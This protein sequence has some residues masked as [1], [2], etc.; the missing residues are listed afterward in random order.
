MRG[1]WL[2]F[3]A[4][5]AITAGCQAQPVAP[6]ET[7]SPPPTATAEPT[8][9]PP[10]TST[11]VPTPTVTPTPFP[12][13][14]PPA[15]PLDPFDQARRLGRGVNLGNALEAPTEGEWGV[16]LE[17]AYFRLIAEAGFDT[18]RVPIRWSAHAMAEPPYTI[19]AAFFQRIDWV[20]E[21]AFANGLN[22]VINM[23]H[24]D[25]LTEAPSTHRERF[26]AMWRQI[27][28]RYGDMPDGLY[29]EPLNEPYGQLTAGTWNTIVADASAAIREA[30][31]AHT[32]V[33]DGTDWA[34][35]SA[36]GKLDLP[37]E[38]N[39]AVCTF[40]LY[41]PHM[42]THQGAEWMDDTYGTTGVQWPG[43]PETPLTPVPA[44][45]DVPWIKKWFEDY[46][47]QPTDRNPAGPGPILDQI[48]WAV[49]YAERLDCPLWL[50]EFGAYSKADL[51]S[52]A[53]WTR[54]VRQEAEVRGISWAYWEFGAG[55]GIYDRDA[56]QWNEELLR[57]LIPDTK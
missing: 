5:V 35:A 54:F 14:T 3:V 18:V 13:V 40:H 10:S 50:G 30:D 49:R 8:V 17:E 9:P 43:P 53:N 37:A 48:E 51:Q 32:L 11:P 25:A 56:G 7:P 34:N 4:V 22:V 36:L 28:R 44:T 20:L 47:T 16:V 12:T 52:R 31:K 29:Y 6:T 41:E 57:A 27:A 42:F 45:N 46:N 1:L 24:Y 2:L 23:H 19:D 33:I 39:N 55:F 21:N 38:E 15:D 26:I